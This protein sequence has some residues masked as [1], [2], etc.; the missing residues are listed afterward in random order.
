MN[1]HV[2]PAK[3]HNTSFNVSVRLLDLFL[4]EWSTEVNYSMYF[5]QCA[6]SYCS[7]TVNEIAQFVYALTLLISLY[8]GLALIFRSIASSIIITMLKLKD[9]RGNA[10]INSGIY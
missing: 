8:G 4:E 10:T 7:Y 1:E 3:Q 5:D 6:P 9:H 2:L